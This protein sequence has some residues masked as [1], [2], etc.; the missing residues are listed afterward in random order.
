VDTRTKIVSCDEA[1]TAAGG[2]PVTIVTGSFDVLLAAHARELEGAR[3]AGMLLVAVTS[4]P[5]SLLGGRARAEM[6]A[7]LAV[8]D[9]VV[10][11]DDGQMDGF[12]TAFPQARI[13][14]LE[15]AH[16]QRMRELKAYVERRQSK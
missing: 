6:V 3:G 7:A 1:R 15:A 8:V 16:E 10:S 11:L 14:R 5:Q 9:F 2:K 12:L 13:V 4:P